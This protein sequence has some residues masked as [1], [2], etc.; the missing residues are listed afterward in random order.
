MSAPAYFAANLRRLRS[1]RGL[2]QAAL[3][4]KISGYPQGIGAWERGEVSPTITS[5]AALAEALGVEAYEL[6]L[7]PGSGRGSE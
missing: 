6:L 5:L 3:A 2:S 4:K 7:P 1:A